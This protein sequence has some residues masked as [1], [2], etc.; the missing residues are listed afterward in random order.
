[1]RLEA[2]GESYNVLIKHDNITYIKTWIE[3]AIKDWITQSNKTTVDN[4]DLVFNN[5]RFKSNQEQLYVNIDEYAGNIHS[6]KWRIP[7]SLR[8]ID[9][10][11]AIKIHSK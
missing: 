8:V 9:P 11:A 3:V 6:N 4:K 5:A 2:Y 10:A 7:M 1:M